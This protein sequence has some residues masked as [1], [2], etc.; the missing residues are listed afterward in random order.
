[1][2]YCFCSIQPTTAAKE[3]IANSVGKKRTNINKQQE[4]QQNAKTHDGL[5]PKTYR[6]STIKIPPIEMERD[7][8]SKSNSQISVE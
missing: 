7:E 2:D 5:F 8:M 4:Q 6:D 3:T 1:M